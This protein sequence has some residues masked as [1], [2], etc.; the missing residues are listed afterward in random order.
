MKEVSE[1]KQKF[2][3][4]FFKALEEKRD[5]CI[6]RN[7]EEYPQKMGDD[8]DI[9]VD[10]KEG[11][12]IEDVVVPIIKQ[13]GWD[14][15]I[16]L[17]QEGFTPVVCMYTTDDTVDIC[18]ID[19]YTK[20]LWRGNQFADGKAVLDTKVRFKNFLV[21][22]HGA[23]LAITLT[24]EF[25]GSGKV[26][27]KYRTKMANFA[28]DDKDGFYAVLSGIYGDLTDKLYKYC[29]NEEFE[30]ID[31]LAKPFKHKVRKQS[32]L[33][34]L[35]CSFRGFTA[36][37]GNW[38]HPEGKLIAFVGPDG[39]GKTTLIGKLDDYLERFFPHNSKIYHRRYEI[40]PELKT[41]LGL[42]SM[43]GKIAGGKERVTDKQQEEIQ[44][45]KKRSFLSILASLFVVF[46]YTLEYSVGSIMAYRLLTKRTL[47]LYDRYYYDHFVQPTTRDV[48][49]PI[50]HF[51]LALVRKPNLT[52][53]LIA[54][55]DHIFKRK[56]DLNAIEI[57]NQN[58]YLNRILKCCKNVEDLNMEQLNADQV[59]AEVF[60]MT[61]NKF[62]GFR[63]K[64]N[65]K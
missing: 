26:R 50:R 12:V 3:V 36:R 32:F 51:L 60:R 18:Q 9:I 53:H 8:I 62:Y 30:K 34:Y 24:K 5:Y 17:R 63:P 29:V 48:I 41:G 15:H 7:Y 20:F 49:W 19:F 38:F 56:Q 22:G 55:G 64:T 31:K 2:I 52:V 27:K 42:S 25:M 16:K 57:D 14:Y 37:I 13:L 44:K 11:D 61:I 21:A 23:D 40:F 65:A 4:D 54:S 35:N 59:A 33:K 58:Y 43:K 39:S 10:A 47:I 1:V 46:Y 45:K 28:K 6:L